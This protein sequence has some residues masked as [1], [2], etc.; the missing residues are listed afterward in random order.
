MH[1]LGVCLGGIG[2]SAVAF[3]SEL[4]MTYKR[5]NGA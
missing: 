2:V 1:F 3:I 4:P 5:G